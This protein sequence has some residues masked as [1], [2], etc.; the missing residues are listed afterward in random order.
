MLYT[1][2]VETQGPPAADG[3]AVYCCG[4][5]P[6]LQAIRTNHPKADLA[7]L[8]RHGGQWSASLHLVRYDWDKAAKLKPRDAMEAL[9]AN[10]AREQLE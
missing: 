10:W 7:L 8:E 5:E 3:T 2:R 1:V 4:P 6:L 9:D